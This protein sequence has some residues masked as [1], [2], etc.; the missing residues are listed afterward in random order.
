ML[1]PGVIQVRTSLP[2][3]TFDAVEFSA[4]VNLV[5][6]INV[7][8]ANDKYEG[9]TEVDETW[10]LSSERR[11]F[12]KRSVTRVTGENLRQLAPPDGT[13][14]FKAV[15]VMVNLDSYSIPKAAISF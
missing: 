14:L 8:S 10:V 1:F 11:C 15:Y 2:R 9:I 4:C 7:C 6:Y 12:E 5:N 3:V 13:S